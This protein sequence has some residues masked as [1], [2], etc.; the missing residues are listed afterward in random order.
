MEAVGA[1]KAETKIRERR[2]LET[3]RF[4]TPVCIKE[5]RL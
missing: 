2:A 4:P 1:M 5:E 3:L